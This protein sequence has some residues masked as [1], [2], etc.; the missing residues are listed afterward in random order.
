MV[1]VVLGIAA[2]GSFAGAELNVDIDLTEET[3]S[4]KSQ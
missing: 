1:H 3:Q 2:A 4:D